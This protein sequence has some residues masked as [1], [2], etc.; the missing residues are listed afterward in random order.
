MSEGPSPGPMK[1]LP[2][3]RSGLGSR[4]D[5]CTLRV[6]IRQSRETQQS[7]DILRI[8]QTTD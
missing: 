7:A 8:L 3:I 5:G 1:Q 4:P 2:L 6:K